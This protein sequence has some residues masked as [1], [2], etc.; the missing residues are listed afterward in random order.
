[1]KT[2]LELNTSIIKL[3]Q[4]GCEPETIAEALQLQPELVK[5]IID[6]LSA[7]K[8]KMTLEQKYGDL[9]DIAIRTLMD[10]A[11]R[12]EN[13]SARVRAAEMLNNEVS[14]GG[15]LDFSYDELSEAL[16]KGRSIIG[17]T[18]KVIKQGEDNS[19]NV[20]DLKTVN[21]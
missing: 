4:D 3:Y 14:G 5:I 9:K 2:N 18:M 12:S 13:D 1:M 21:A 20:L 17:E 7:R 10:V 19:L 15:A 6:N 8:K 16:Q 11:E